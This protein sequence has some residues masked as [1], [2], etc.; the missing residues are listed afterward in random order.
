[1]V[2]PKTVQIFIRMFF[3]VTIMAPMLLLA[4]GAA[5]DAAN[6]ARGDLWHP[7]LSHL[8]TNFSEL[9]AGTRFSPTSFGQSIV[10]TLV[11]A[12]V[13]VVFQV[14]SSTLAA[15]AF[16]FFDFRAKKLIYGCIVFSYLVP[17]VATVVPLFFA[18]TAFG[19]KE[20]AIGILFPY[21]LFSPY[22]LVMLRG[23]FESI[24][25]SLIEQ[26]FMDG[27][28]PWNM[29]FRIALPMTRSFVALISLVTFVSTWNSFLWPRLIAGTGFPTL[30]VEISS[31]QT[32]YSGN[33]NLV[34]VATVVAMLPTIGAFAFGQRHIVPSLIENTQE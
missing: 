23:S 25:Q 13:T 26:A 20:T 6:L 4:I 12:L 11:L 28:G 21:L 9:E 16:A 8:L 30:T 2:K 31:L 17:P 18:T 19:L 5:S 33:W 10:N 1:M 32:Q 14:G 34:L 7:S 29:L 22:A 3:A 27:L 15:F 24:P